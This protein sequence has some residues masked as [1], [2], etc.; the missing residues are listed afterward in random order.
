MKKVMSLLLIFSLVLTMG[1]ILAENETNTSSEDIPEPTLYDTDVEP[2]ED[3]T[4]TPELSCSNAD[5]TWTTFN[6][7]CADSCAYARTPEEIACTQAITDGCDCGEDKCWNGKSCEEN[8]RPEKQPRADVKPVPIRADALKAKPIA[9]Q[10]VIRAE[11]KFQA[12]QSGE[13]PCPERC[14]CEDNVVRCTFANGSKELVMR[15]TEKGIVFKARN[16]EAHTGVN[17]YHADDGGVFGVFK[18]EQTKR[19]ILPDEA[20]E[21]LKK[22]MRKRNNQSIN[23]SEENITLNEDGHYDVKAKK[24]ARLFWVIPVKE[25]MHTQVDAET[26]SIIKQRNSWWGFLARDVRVDDTG[27]DVSDSE[28]PSE[29]VPVE[30]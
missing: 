10:N 28:V 26:G 1:F 24:R 23:L 19:I 9:V 5:G 29:E 15:E 2:T 30:E 12:I 21:K 7:G 8:E 27:E 18:G 20:M 11:N 16:Y 6:N 17:L 3:V 14:I 22:A 25:K 4:L 13:S